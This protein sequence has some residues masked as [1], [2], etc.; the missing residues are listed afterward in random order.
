MAS[1]PAISPAVLFAAIRRASK[2]LASVVDSLEPVIAQSAAIAS[3]QLALL[4]KDGDL[5]QRELDD[6]LAAWALEVLG[7]LERLLGLASAP[8]YLAT[9]DD[10]QKRVIRDLREEVAK[11]RAQLARLE[12][13]ATTQAAPSEN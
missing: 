5:P 7:P 1:Q 2:L 8:P 11:L 4:D 3:G 6:H 9:Q 13:L 10:I 12:T